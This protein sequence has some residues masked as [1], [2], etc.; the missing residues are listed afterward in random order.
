M[1]YLYTYFT[2]RYL[3]FTIYRLELL[4]FMFSAAV[5]SNVLSGLFGEIFSVIENIIRK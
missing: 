5:N 1:W 3:D 2:Y 4:L